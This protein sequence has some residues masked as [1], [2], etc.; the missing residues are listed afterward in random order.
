MLICEILSSL[1]ITRALAQEKGLSPRAKFQVMRN[2]GVLDGAL[3]DYEA[4]KMSI[5]E[6]MGVKIEPLPENPDMG[7]FIFENEDHKAAFDREHQPL[8]LVDVALPYKISALD[9]I[10]F[11]SVADLMGLGD[12]VELST[13]ES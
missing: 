9:V 8:T 4:Q 2:L 10:S 11:V 12:F 5:V 6:V 1:D 3:K 13:L 7:R